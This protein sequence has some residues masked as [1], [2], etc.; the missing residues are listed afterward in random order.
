[1]MLTCVRKYRG[2]TVRS[3]ALTAACRAR[4]VHDLRAGSDPSEGRPRR[5][6]NSQ[7]GDV[8]RVYARLPRSIP[9]MARHREGRLAG[10]DLLR[11][12]SGVARRVPVRTIQYAGYRGLDVRTLSTLTAAG[13]R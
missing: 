13:R 5:G 6:L 11:R 10:G 1:M 4:Q 2:P 7:Q 8:G 9:A 12:G 3:A